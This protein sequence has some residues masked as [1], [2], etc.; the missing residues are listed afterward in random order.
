[1]PFD[2]ITILLILTMIRYAPPLTMT[3]QRQHFCLTVAH[4]AFSVKS[5]CFDKMSAANS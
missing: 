3:V 1:M 2:F 4:N 5:F